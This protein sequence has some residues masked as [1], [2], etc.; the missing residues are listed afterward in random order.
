MSRR[1]KEVIQYPDSAYK[2]SHFPHEIV[3]LPHK[4]ADV[5][6]NSTPE[7]LSFQQCTYDLLAGDFTGI[8]ARDMT[9]TTLLRED[10]TRLQDRVMDT[11][12]SEGI[13]AIDVKIGSCEGKQR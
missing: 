3:I 5:F 7:T 8:T 4:W 12:V 2:I 13:K 1:L 9:L 11:V 6:K 10:V